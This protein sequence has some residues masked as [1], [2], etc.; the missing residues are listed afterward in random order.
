MPFKDFESV[1][2][3][4]S[5]SDI[6]VYTAAIN[7]GNLNKEILFDSKNQKFIVQDPENSMKAGKY[8]IEVTG[9]LNSRPNVRASLSI[10]LN[11]K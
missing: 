9:Y 4:S 11:V 3:C 10:T 7:K 8:S 5:S 1:P 2:L 6:I